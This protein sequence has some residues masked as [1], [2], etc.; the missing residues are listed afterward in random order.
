MALSLFVVDVFQTSLLAQLR[1]NDQGLLPLVNQPSRL[2]PLGAV[3][4]R[5]NQTRGLLST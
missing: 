5:L 3:A 1:D 4:P 2:L